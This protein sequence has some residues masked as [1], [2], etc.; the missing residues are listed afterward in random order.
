M[1]H[2]IEVSHLSKKY[3]IG[4]KE[5]YHT[6]RDIL[7]NPFESLKNR[8]KEFFA[9]KN[10]SFKVKEGETLGI[11]GANGAGK[12]TLLKILSRVTPPT[13]G[14]AV[15]RGRVASL[16][17]VGTGFHQ[18][19]TGKENIYL[20]G[21]ILGMSKKEISNKFDKIV[22][23]AEIDNFL[24][25]PVK[26]YSSGMYIRLAFSIAIHLEPEIL[27]IDEI[28]AV[29]DIDFQKKSLSKLNKISHKRNK[30]ILFVSHNMD[31]IKSLCH[32]SILL[33]HGKMI[34]HGTT[35]KVVQKYLFS[36]QSEKA[37]FKNDLKK[38]A[39]ITQVKIKNKKDQLEIK[40]K[41]RVNKSKKGIVIRCTASTA[42]GTLIYDS[43][44]SVIGSSK[45]FHPGEYESTVLFDFSLI[46][47]GVFQIQTFINI[48]GH[49][50][51]ID[52][53]KPLVFNFNKTEKIST[54][55]ANQKGVLIN[56]STWQ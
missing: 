45:N 53:A 9:L 43:N 29:G 3:K 6:L 25:T 15:I 27:I 2:I 40:I 55:D 56:Q 38:I 19:L 31:I 42:E 20:S 5:N 21:S 4:G 7:S 34:M 30:T 39:K 54:K 10:I 32:R 17:E 49:Q 48:E 52:K 24:N 33:D 35:S 22:E 46:K 26:H 13:E 47:S 1:N 11:I 50:F 51:A 8:K 28:L 44:N 41:Y 12:S 36:N 37:I 23:F 14:K 16:L 18:E